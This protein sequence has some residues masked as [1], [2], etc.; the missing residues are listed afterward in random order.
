MSGYDR[1][2]TEVV[3][4]V[5]RVKSPGAPARTPAPS[6]WRYGTGPTL[7]AAAPGEAVV[8]SREFAGRVPACGPRAHARPGPRGE[9]GAGTQARRRRPGACG[10][11]AGPRAGAQARSG[12]GRRCPGPRAGCGRPGGPRRQP[13]GAAGAGDRRRED[14][15]PADM[16][17]LDLDL[18]ADL[19]VDTVKQAETFAAVREAFGIPRPEN[20]NLR[21]YPTL[22]RVI[23][24]VYEA[25][26]ELRAAAPAAPAPAAPAA[27]PAP[28]APAPA[29]PA[30][31]PVEQ[32]VLAIV[33][34]KTGY[35]S[36]M[37]DLDLDLEADLGID[38]VKQAETFAAVREAFDIP[39]PENLTLR[40]YP[41][42]RHVIEF[43][44]DAP[45]RPEGGT[46]ASGAGSGGAG[47]AGSAPAL[48]RPALSPR[49]TRWPRRCWRSSPRR[50]ATRPR[51]STSTWTWRP[52][53]AST[54]SSRPRPSRRSARRSTSRAP[55]EPEACATT[56]PCAQRDRVRLRGTG[57][58]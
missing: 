12:S 58:S 40:D 4:R 51:C 7:R 52:T 29:A 23:G 35:P 36:E 32:Q 41:T 18:E 17:D 28:V 45:A 56:R 9:A 8:R 24:F 46:G 3:K 55:D 22:R 49:P 47:C 39:R 11:Y 33:A 53:W 20:L 5:L 48:S 54:R 26:P 31:N 57:P 19:G 15:L 10:A 43:V 37:L 2:E 13:G 42:L 25:R 38:T 14:R 6:P 50:P 44:Y 30:V 34:E 1:A 27:A 16:L 21:D